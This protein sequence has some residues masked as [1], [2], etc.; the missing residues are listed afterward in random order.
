MRIYVDFDDVVTETARELCRLADRLYGRQVAYEDVFAFELQVSFGLSRPQI[1]A[2]MA[3]AHSRDMLLAYRETPGACDTLR[4][5]VDQGRDIE[6]V[7]GRPLATN[8]GTREW[9]A[10]RGLGDLPVVHVDKFGREPPPATPDAPRALSVEEFCARRY[11]FAV[12]DSPV[13]LGHLAKLPGCR[14]AVFSRPWNATYALPSPLFAR[15][16][17][18]DEVDA[19]SRQ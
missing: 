9:L 10:R 3:V 8:A 15:C 7:T 14:V 1:D 11:D 17:D 18:W 12:E 4:K 19:W 5:W 13:G 6:I 16:R 2:L